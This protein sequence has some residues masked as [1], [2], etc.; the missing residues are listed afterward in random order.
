MFN[1]RKFKYI[2]ESNNQIKIISYNILAPVVI[3]ND[4]L[5]FVTH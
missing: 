5:Y 4:I 3:K 2:N 1:N